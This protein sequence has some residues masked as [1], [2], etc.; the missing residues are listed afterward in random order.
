MFSM[1]PDTDNLSKYNNQLI[2]NVLGEPDPDVLNREQTKERAKMI[3]IRS[4]KSLKHGFTSAA[5][6]NNCIIGIKKLEIGLK[7]FLDLQIRAYMRNKEN[8]GQGSHGKPCYPL[9][10]PT[11]VFIHD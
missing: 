5:D 11:L 7:S 8:S 10:A 6:F 9:R 1:K 4:S 3:R 2:L